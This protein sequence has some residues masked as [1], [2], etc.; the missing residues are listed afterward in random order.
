MTR[1][2]NARLA[3]LAYLL[4]IA[5]AFP[6]MVLLDRATSGTGMTAKLATMAQHAGD[7]RLG[8]VLSMIGSFCALV[9]AVTLY[10]LTRDE[11]RDLAL[12][13]MTCR[14]TEGATGAASVLVTLG[15]LAVVTA[16][17]ADTPDRAAAQVVGTF[18]LHQSSAIIGAT[19]FA[20]GSTTF[21]WLLLR[22]RMI[23]IWLAWTG[24]VGSALLV[25]GLP[26]QLMR[27]L[28]GPAAQLMWIPVAIFEVVVAVWFL[29]KG[30]S[31]S[32][33]RALSEQIR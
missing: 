10:A 22:G 12:L 25:V 23:P 20:L 3:G 28:A 15:L 9:L 17:G 30:A 6:S 8:V 18:A 33:P 24:F 4:Y 19:F 1:T 7:V 32:P 29:I 13:A 27:V 21:C 26:L 11:D 16:S 2:T 31:I 5:A 14:V